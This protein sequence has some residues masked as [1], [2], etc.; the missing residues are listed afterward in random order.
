M[1]SLYNFRFS[2]LIARLKREILTLREELEMV[3]GEQRNEQLTAE[4]KQRYAIC[5][6]ILF[7]FKMFIEYEYDFLKY[8]IWLHFVYCFFQ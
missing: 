6:L 7:N 4:E 3:T 8:H 2:Q 1:T 5:N